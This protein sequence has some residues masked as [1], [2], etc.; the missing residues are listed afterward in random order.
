MKIFK[1]GAASVVMSDPNGP[2]PYFGWPTATRLQ[3]G[4]IAVVASGF[5]LRHVCPFGKTVISYSTDEGKTY[6]APIPVI[7]TVL[8][9]R[10]GGIVAYGEQSVIVTSFNNSVAFQ[11]AQP[12]ADDESLAYLDTVTPEAE[13]AALGVGFRLSH[14]GGATFGPIYKSPVGSPH[15][16]LALP[17]GTLL[18]VGRV[19]SPADAKVEGV[20]RIEAHRIHRDG[21]TEYVGKIENVTVDGIE[22]LSCE[23]HAILLEGGRILVHIR[24]CASGIFTI[25]QAVS[26][27]GGRTWSKPRPIMDRTEGAPPHLFRHSS[28]LLLCTY[29][30]RKAPYGVRVMFSRDEGETWDV[31]Y[32]LYEGVSA[33]L[34]YPSTVE[35]SDGS[36]LTVFYAKEHRDGPAIIMQQK[37]RFEL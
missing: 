2:R 22:P 20:D 37:W 9:D 33:D 26:V 7:D 8:D 24:I 5:R 36:L 16:P 1:L 10:D 35:L 4:R 3:D 25:Y 23:P 32:E 34:G 12:T 30:H 18:W 13:A 14:D 21:T 17:D 6:T 28:G 29:G 19:F 15:G 31:G 11:R 27:D